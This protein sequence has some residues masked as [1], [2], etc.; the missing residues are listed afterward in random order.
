MANPLLSQ[1]VSD[2][3]FSSFFGSSVIGSQYRDVSFVRGQLAGWLAGPQNIEA[4]QHEKILRA[5]LGATGSP[6]A[7]PA[8]NPYAPGVFSVSPSGTFVPQG[9]TPLAM[10]APTKNSSWKW[11]LAGLAGLLFFRRKK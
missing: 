6:I 7:G 10:A 8:S 9:T 2:Y 4:L 5:I 11:V 3:E 1:G